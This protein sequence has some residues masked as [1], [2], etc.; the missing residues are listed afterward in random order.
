M[1]Y[2]F[3]DAILRRKLWE[4]IKE[5]HDHMAEPWAVM[6]D[7]NCVLHIDERIWSPVTLSEIREFKQCVDECTL[8]D[9]KSLGAFY[10]WNNK[11]GGSDRVYSR[12]DRVLA[13]NEWILALPDSEVYYRNEGT[14]DYCPAIIRWAG[15]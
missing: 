12:I 13:H 5:I 4:D 11:Q 14:F 7:F 10:T 8:Q 6:G 1:V 15:D 2:G 9:M 3:N